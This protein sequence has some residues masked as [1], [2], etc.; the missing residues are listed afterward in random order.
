[1]C[2]KLITIDLG[3]TLLKVFSGKGG[4]FYEN[5]MLE[6]DPS[7]LLDEEH[8]IVDGKCYVMGIGSYQH[9][10]IKTNKVFLPQVLYCVS[11]N[12]ENTKNTVNL[13]LGLPVSQIE[14]KNLLIDALSNKTFDIIVNGSSK[15]LK[16]GTVGVVAEGVSSFYSLP[17]RQGKIAI[18]DLGSRTTNVT[19][20][21]AGKQD[22]HPFTINIGTNNLLSNIKNKMLSMGITV[23]LEKVWSL[24]ECSNFTLDTFEAEIKEHMDLL[25]NEIIKDCPL[26]QFY[27]I[28]LCGG[29]VHFLKNEFKKSYPSVDTIG[30]YLFANA[31]G[32]YN[33]GCA[34]G[35]DK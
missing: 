15:K 27:N 12:L 16:I 10:F 7:L 29:G 33:I 4:V 28:K 14:S 19:T 35:L 13:I 5:R 31:E 1:M 30:K 24:L 25:K 23:E 17:S 21:T 3:N 26:L 2:R 22:A 11:K 20:C 6:K 18:V 8:I 9:Q 32:N 34:K